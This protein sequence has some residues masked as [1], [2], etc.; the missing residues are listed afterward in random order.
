MSAAS[1]HVHTLPIYD[2]AGKVAALSFG[3]IR[4]PRR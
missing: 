1:R 4:A 2:H 3:S